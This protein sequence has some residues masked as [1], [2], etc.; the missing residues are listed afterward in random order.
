MLIKYHEFRDIPV[1]LIPTLIEHI[2]LAGEIQQLIYTNVTP[3]PIFDT[4]ELS[5]Q[6][7]KDE[8]KVVNILAQYYVD[9]SMEHSFA[10]FIDKYIDKL[11]ADVDKLQEC[12]RIAND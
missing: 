7:L 2:E 11:K 12:W 1:G 3:E 5:S 9:E 6:T 8:W 4:F 10:C